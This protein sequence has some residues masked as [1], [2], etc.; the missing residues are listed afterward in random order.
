[1]RSRVK[2]TIQENH[3]ISPGERVLAA[4]SG[5]GDS[6]ALAHLLWTLQSELQF[7][8]SLLYIQHGLR[9][10]ESNREEEFVKQWAERYQLPLFIEDIDVKKR[11]TER[12]ISVEAAARELRYE[13]FAKRKAE[14]GMDSVA[15]AH[16]ADDQAETICM[17]FLRG[18]G[19]KGLAGMRLKQGCYFRPLLFERKSEIEKYLKQEKID[20]VEDSSNHSMEFRRN[21]MRRELLPY[22]KEN[23]NPN[24]ISTLSQCSL[25]MQELQNYV[26]MEKESIWTKLSPQIGNGH[27]SLSLSALRALPGFLRQ[28]IIKKAMVEFG[29]SERN[30]ESAAIYRALSLMEK[31]NG[32]KEDLLRGLQVQKNEKELCFFYPEEMPLSNSEIFRLSLDR[33]GRNR[34]IKIIGD[35]ILFYRKHHQ[36][37]EKSHPAK[38]VQ[39]LDAD[40]LPAE[41]QFRFP[42]SEDVMI[43]NATGNQK[44][45]KDV[46]ADAKIPQSMRRR[47]PVLARGNEIIWA[48]GCRV[49]YPYGVSE[50]TENLICLKVLGRKGKWQK[51]KKELQGKP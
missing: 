47:I 12:R 32:K 10:A 23:W 8:L 42:Q 50:K 7:S 17:N 43:I 33:T 5:G 18:S 20:W 44:R 30:I 16:H 1:M 2:K 38:W 22:L 49:A 26:E 48:I 37:T 51:L 29:I 40:S 3:L 35:Y 39:N 14:F 15:L 4:F 45:L 25:H 28:E 13:A 21:R 46:L 41:I 34:Y 36:K 31:E 11:R 24:L 6:A 19:I 9:G 27:L